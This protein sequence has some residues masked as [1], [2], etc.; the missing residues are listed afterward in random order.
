MPKNDADPKYDREDNKADKKKSQQNHANFTE[1]AQ[2]LSSIN[3]AD[4]VPSLNGI[5][6]NQV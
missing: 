3:A 1:E 6:K 4:S 5:P 2:T